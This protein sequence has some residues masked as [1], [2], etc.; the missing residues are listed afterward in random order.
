MH[1][2]FQHINCVFFSSQVAYGT[3]PLDIGNGETINIPKVLRKMLPEKNWQEYL[4]EHSEVDSLGNIKPDT[5]SGQIGRNDFLQI[6]LSY[7]G[8]ILHDMHVRAIVY[9]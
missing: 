1:N 3:K 4:L 7:S 6:L 8:S 2:P 5:Y 9:E